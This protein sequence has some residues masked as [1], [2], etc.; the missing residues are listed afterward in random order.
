M[1]ID[2][3]NYW[4]EIDGI[5]E[6]LTDP[7]TSTSEIVQ[8]FLPGS[9]VVKTLNHVGYHDIEDQARPAGKPGRT[10]VAIAGDESADLA[11][12]AA[13]VDALGFDPVIAG[14]LADGVRLEPGTELFGADVDAEEVRARLDRFRESERGRIVARARAKTPAEMAQPVPDDSVVTDARAKREI[15]GWS[16]G[17]VDVPWCFEAVS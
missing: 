11:A 12:V 15:R 2:A 10:A 9:R 3:M 8:A 1:S 17:D 13:L 6:D 7:R 14:S 5:R 4:W 16:P